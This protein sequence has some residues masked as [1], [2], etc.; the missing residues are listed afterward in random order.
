MTLPSP[1]SDGAAIG[2]VAPVPCV[3]LFADRVVIASTEQLSCDV[4]E[5]VVPLVELSFDYS[6]TRLRASDDRSRVLRAAGGV[7]ETIDRDRASEGA[8][9]RAI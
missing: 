1:I 5:L 3:R 6:G 4:V 7:V 8:A 2:Q 9:R